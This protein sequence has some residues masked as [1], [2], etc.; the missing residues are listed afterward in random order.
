M[1]LRESE[2]RFRDVTEAASDW[3]WEMD[4]NL[5]FTYLSERFYALT[6]IAPQYVLGRTRWEL[7]GVDSAADPQKWR[8]HR[9]LLEKHLSFRDFIYFAISSIK[10]N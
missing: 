10:P 3:I 9:E 8:R 5:R 7:A 2:T 6:G 4:E 1:A